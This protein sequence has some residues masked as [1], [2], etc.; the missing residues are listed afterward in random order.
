MKIIKLVIS[1]AAEAELGGLFITTKEMVPLRH[2][3]FEIWRPQPPYPVQTDNTTSAGIVNKKIVQKKMK[4]MDTRFHWLH[5]RERQGQLRFYWDTGSKNWGDY[6]TK[7]QPPE[8][9]E[10][11]RPTNAG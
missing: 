6:S 7:N 11:Q 1:Y 5:W 10:A 3:L 8:Y 2:N 4:T 9:Y